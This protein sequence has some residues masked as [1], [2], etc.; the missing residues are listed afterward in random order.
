MT[1]VKQQFDAD[2]SAL[3]DKYESDGLSNS[4]IEDSLVWHLELV[5]SR[6]DSQQFSVSTD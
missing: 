2:L 6:P 3:I 1:T 5:E 4:E